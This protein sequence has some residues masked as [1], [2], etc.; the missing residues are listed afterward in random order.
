M[1]TATIPATGRAQIV[2]TQLASR[3]VATIP[4]ALAT[5]KQA[6]LGLCIVMEVSGT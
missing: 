1:R 4:E 3:A 2:D 5:A 6:T